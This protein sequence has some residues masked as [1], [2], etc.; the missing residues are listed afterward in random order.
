MAVDQFQ[1]SIR[2]AIGEQAACEAD[3]V[4]QQGQRLPLGFGMQARVQLVRRQLAGA[5]ADVSDDAV[6]DGHGFTC[7]FGESCTRTTRSVNIGSPLGPGSSW[8]KSVSL[9]SST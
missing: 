8:I 7:F 1:P 4:V 5:D 2:Q 3:L 6:A 9:P